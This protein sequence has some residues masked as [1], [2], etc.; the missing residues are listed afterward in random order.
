MKD[1]DIRYQSASLPT[2]APISS[3]RKKTQAGDVP[4]ACYPPSAG[5]L[6]RSQLRTEDV[7]RNADEFQHLRQSHTFQMA[8]ELAARVTSGDRHVLVNPFSLLCWAS[9]EA[10]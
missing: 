4:S 5:F 1:L 10:P 7:V 2:N 9:H 3:G 8:P 6:V